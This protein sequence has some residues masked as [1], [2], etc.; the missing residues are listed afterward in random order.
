MES[1]RL[2]APVD[3]WSGHPLFPTY[4]RGAELLYELCGQARRPLV[5]PVVPGPDGAKQPSWKDLL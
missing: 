5:I 3:P 2:V 1:E 4:S